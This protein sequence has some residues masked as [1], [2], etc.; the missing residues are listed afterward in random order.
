MSAMQPEVLAGHEW[1]ADWRHAMA[2]C[3][4]WLNVVGYLWRV[5]LGLSA[6]IHSSGSLLTRSTSPV[7]FHHARP[8]T[9]C[10]GVPSRQVLSVAIKQKDT[11]EQKSQKG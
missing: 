2:R 8:W 5:S 3:Q 6:G 10:R 4:T 9:R 11:G 7:R 1:E